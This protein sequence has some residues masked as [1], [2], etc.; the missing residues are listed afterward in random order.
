[1]ERDAVV[2]EALAEAEADPVV[3]ADRGERALVG[4][5]EGGAP[6]HVGG[7]DGLDGLEAVGGG[8]LDVVDAEDGADLGHEAAVLV[9]VDGGAVDEGADGAVG[10]DDAADDGDG[11]RR[12]DAQL[13]A[14]GGGLEL[15]PG[16]A[17]VDGDRRAPADRLRLGRHA[18]GEGHLALR[19]ELVAAG[20][21]QHGRAGRGGRP[22]HDG[23]RH[24]GAGGVVDGGGGQHAQ[25]G[26]VERAGGL[27][28]GVDL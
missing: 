19:K 25:A 16:W 24:L 8:D 4:G 23:V 21:E 26:G 1:G 2:E 14:G 15:D 7:G 27:D 13:V 11:G 18:A 10:V 28:P 3:E 22:L 6:D 17:G 5:V 9:E 20:L 12:V